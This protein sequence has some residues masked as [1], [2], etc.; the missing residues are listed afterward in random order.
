MAKGKGTRLEIKT[1]DMY[2]LSLLLSLLSLHAYISKCGLLNKAKVICGDTCT[3][4]GGY[5]GYHKQY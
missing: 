5:L 4:L 2:R 1:C 3:K